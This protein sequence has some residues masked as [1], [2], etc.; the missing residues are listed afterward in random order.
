MLLLW[1]CLQFHI[2]G[3]SFGGNV[4][5]FVSAGDKAVGITVAADGAEVQRIAAAAFRQGET[6]IAADA[7]EIDLIRVRRA[8]DAHFTGNS[9]AVDGAAACRKRS[10][11]DI[12]AD[13]AKVIFSGRKSG[14]GNPA[15]CS[16]DSERVRA[17]AHQFHIG[18]DRFDCDAFQC[19]LA[20][21]E[22]SQR[23]PRQIRAAEKP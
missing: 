22:N 10:Q 8:A 18:R 2:A 7:V 6:Q 21:Q 20:G 3:N 23:L 19:G 16:A 13:G 12:P 5:G 4:A 17:A 1:L 11:G 15:A 9:F 14:A